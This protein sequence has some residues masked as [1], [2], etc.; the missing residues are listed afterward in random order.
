VLEVNVQGVVQ[1]EDYEQLSPLVETSV[2]E[3]GKVNFLVHVSDL[4]GLSLPAMWQDIK[5]YKKHHADVARVAMVAE[6]SARK[7][8][9]TVS[10]P[11][12][13]AE[14]RFFP[15]A[16]VSEARAW[17]TESPSVGP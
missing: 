16:E 5:L 8:M 6:D 7:W 9:A 11:F 15:E 17:V 10:K 2:R 1:A 4:K 12:L 14:V 13:R 3:H